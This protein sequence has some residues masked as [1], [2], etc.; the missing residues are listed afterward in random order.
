MSTRQPQFD[1]KEV[2]KRVIEMAVQLGVLLLLFLWCLRI[3]EPFILVIIWAMIVAIAL[4]PIYTRL[5][6]LLHQQEKW[7]ATLLVVALIG[8][9]VLPTMALTDSLLNGAQALVA[10]DAAGNLQ[11]PLPPDSVAGWPIVG[12]R[13]Y[14]LW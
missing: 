1:F 9:L 5:A 11:I 8:I 6:R 2:Q 4:Y 7:A 14:E 3:V 10:A 12:A 13:A